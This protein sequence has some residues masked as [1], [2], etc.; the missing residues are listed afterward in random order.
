MVTK[1]TGSQ[2][3]VLYI[4]TKGAEAESESP[5]VVTTSQESEF[6]SESESIKLLRLRLRTVCYN[7]TLLGWAKNNF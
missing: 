6:G 7:L 3:Q 4:G 5:G 1:T 2:F